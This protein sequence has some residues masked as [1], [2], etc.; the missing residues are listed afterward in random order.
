MRIK[1]ISILP[2]LSKIFEKFLNNRINSFIGKNNIINNILF[3]VYRQFSFRNNMPSIDTVNALIEEVTNN[4][5]SKLKCSMVSLHL[6]KAL[7]F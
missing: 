1:P 5:D 6:S 4:L 2:N 3:I 7:I